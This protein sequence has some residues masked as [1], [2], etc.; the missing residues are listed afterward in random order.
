MISGQDL[1]AL[2]NFRGNGLNNR[3]MSKIFNWRFSAVRAAFMLAVASLCLP[4]ST[5]SQLPPTILSLIVDG[6]DSDHLNYALRRLS[7]V[8]RTRNVLIGEVFVTSWIGVPPNPALISG[9]LM[10]ALQSGKVEPREAYLLNQS[11]EAKYLQ[12]AG[13]VSDRVIESRRILKRLGIENS[14]TWV[15]RYKGKDYVFEGFRDPASLFSKDGTF[16]FGGS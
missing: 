5:L 10:Q 16:L 8:K 15:V 4:S 1:S 14:P 2:C 7:Y 6:S 9:D 3:S 12:E 11:Q 13:V